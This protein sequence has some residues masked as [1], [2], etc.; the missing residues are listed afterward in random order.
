MGLVMDRKRQRIYNIVITIVVLAVCGI[1]IAISFAVKARVES[2]AANSAT[3]PVINDNPT[4][5]DIIDE[6][7]D[8]KPNP[9]EIF[10]NLQPTLDTWLSTTVQTPDNVGVMIYD[11][12]HNKIAASHNADTVFNV[13]S[14]YKLLF[15]YDGYR[16][17]AMGR[18]KPNERF[19][20]TKDKGDLTLSQCLDLMIRESY[21]GCADPMASNRTRIARV[22]SLM[23][24]LEMNSTSNIG[25][26]STASDLTKLLRKYWR[27]TDLT[28]QLWNQLADSMLIQPVFTNTEDISTNLRQ[29]LPAGFSNFVNVYNKVGWEWNPEK[30]RWDIYADA[31]IIDFVDYQH[32]YSV[33]VLT[34]NISNANII[35]QLGEMIESTVIS[36][37]EEATK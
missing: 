37:T 12:N 8:D 29:G 25:L 13:A 27:H 15:V 19:V 2:E 21:N 4:S 36:Q 32:Y 31:A 14:V 16:Q 18:E 24:E 28:N 22:N 30:N 35:A 1:V 11:L 7:K 26:A 3:P 20:S 10:I 34:K 6:P 9:N 17:I 23:R 5:N 33:V